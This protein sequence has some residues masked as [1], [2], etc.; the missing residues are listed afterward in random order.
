MIHGA[1][2]GHTRLIT[3]M[4]ASD[5]NRA[6][7]V[8]QLFRGAT[9]RYGIPSRV[10]TD[11]GGENVQVADL[12]TSHRGEGRAIQGRSVHNQRIERLWVDVWNG[13]ASTFH[14]LFHAMEVEGPN[15]QEPLLDI[16]NPMHMWALHCVFLPRLNRELANFVGQ[17]NQHGLRTESHLSPLQL[18]ARDSLARCNTSLTAMRDLFSDQQLPDLP[19][20]GRNIPTLS[21]FERPASATPERLVALRREVDPLQDDGAHGLSHFAR[22]LN[23]LTE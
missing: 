1:I 19:D 2:D 10:R 9:V 12:M 18:F 14:A 3:F 8:L 17:W 16:D 21:A 7:T 13:V 4:H 23:V 20:V 6:A 22:V 5:N 11:H 15:G